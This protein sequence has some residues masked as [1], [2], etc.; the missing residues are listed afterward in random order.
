MAD[1]R[2]LNKT[3]GVRLAFEVER[4]DVENLIETI[5]KFTGDNTISFRIV[6]VDGTLTTRNANEL[7]D[8]KN[9]SRGRIKAVHLTA[10]EPN[11][12]P[13]NVD[14]KLRGDSAIGDSISYDA[15]GPP[16]QVD[17]LARSLDD[18]I[19]GV[20]TDY[21]RVLPPDW[22]WFMGSYF[23]GTAGLVML[24]LKVFGYHSGGVEIP[25][26][27]TLAFPVITLG[28]GLPLAF[29][30]RDSFVPVA[31]FAIG[32]GVRRSRRS[33]ALRG[34]LFVG[35]FLSFILGLGVNYAYD[36]AKSLGESGSKPV[37]TSAIESSKGATVKHK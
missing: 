31:S 36:Q 6:C 13:R 15:S 3:L 5:E 26:P 24:V 21:A 32:D 30:F 37:D 23:A 12:G 29:Y 28:A 11:Y 8:H 2:L 20:K 22:I 9:P 33:Q 4:N 19:D 27:N 18:W 34:L 35:V 16:D 7:L 17:Q 1:D 10:R 25:I 14:F